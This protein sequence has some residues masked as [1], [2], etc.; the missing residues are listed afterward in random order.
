MDVSEKIMIEKPQIW[1]GCTVDGRFLLQS[2]L[3][4]SDHG[5]VYLT[6]IKGP[7][8]DSQNAAIKLIRVTADA[9]S[10][11]QNWKQTRE[12]SHP[13]LIGIFDAGRC[14][15]D[16]TPLLYVVEEYAE[17]NLAQ[18]LPDRALAAD[19]ARGM[20]PPILRALQ[21]VHEKGLVHGRIQPSNILAIGEQVKLSSDTL[22]LGDKAHGMQ[23][24]YD[25]PE[26]A[27]GPI[28]AVTDIWQLGMTIVEVLTQRL[29]FWDRGR[30]S[31]MITPEVPVTVPEPFRAIA[32]RCLQLD[33][34]KR[35]TIREMIGGLETGRLYAERLIANT[36]P[37]ED[38]ASA[39]AISIGRRASLKWYLLG[40]AAVA[41]IAFVLIVKKP[42]VPVSSLAPQSGQTQ[43]VAPETSQRDQTQETETAKPSSVPRIEGK[44]GTGNATSNAVAGT[45]SQ[46][47]VVQRVLPQVSPSARR[48]IR[49]KIKVRIRVDVDAAGKVVK[50]KIESSGPSRYFS[51]LSVDAAKEWRFSPAS[52]GDQTGDRKW[53]LEF[54]FSRAKTEAAAARVKH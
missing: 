49:G 35:L 17:E 22:S 21:F 28:S 36:T 48:T 20:L 51:H 15:L 4:G 44:E 45:D 37:S 18:I 13:N 19:E 14:D 11:L 23:G 5:A 38:A 9:D 47:E 7:A 31:D 43:S 8:G 12:L 3:G 6:S 10:Q 33:P 16:G 40:T 1:V 41:A 39:S 27:S 42:N 53:D 46:G 34:D 25:P 29:P 52:V 32:V 24:M 30:A 26:T 2:Y 50:A 54:G